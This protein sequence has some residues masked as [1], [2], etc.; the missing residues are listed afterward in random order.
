MNPYLTPAGAD[1]RYDADAAPR[2]L[3]LLKRTAYLTPAWNTPLE[4]VEADTRAL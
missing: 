2:T 3:D 4:K 1:A